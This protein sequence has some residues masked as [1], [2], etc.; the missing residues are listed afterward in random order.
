MKLVGTIEEPN[1]EAIAALEPDL[2]ISSKVR[3][4]QIYDELSAIAPTVFAENAGATWKE[5]VLLYGEA[6]GREAAAAR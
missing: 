5:N 1:L 3:H 4:E 2:V 6:V